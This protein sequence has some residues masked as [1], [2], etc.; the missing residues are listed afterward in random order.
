MKIDLLSQS[1]NR[2]KKL[3]YRLTL[4]L[5]NKERHSIERSLRKEKEFNEY[6]HDEEEGRKLRLETWGPF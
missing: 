1:D 2:V 6:L 4:R 5:S 3:E